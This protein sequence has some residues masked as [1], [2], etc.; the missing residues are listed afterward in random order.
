M[1]FP[2]LSDKLIAAIHDTPEKW[3]RCREL[4]AKAA[5]LVKKEKDEADDILEQYRAYGFA[6]QEVEDDKD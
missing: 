1:P 6:V 2:I 5:A 4:Q 3:E